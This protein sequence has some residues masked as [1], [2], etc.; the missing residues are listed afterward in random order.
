MDY[1]RREEKDYY[2]KL[3]NHVLYHV[4]EKMDHDFMY[5]QDIFSMIDQVFM[6]IGECVVT[7]RVEKAEIDS[8]NFTTVENNIHE[9]DKIRRKRERRHIDIGIQ[10][11]S[12]LVR[13]SVNRLVCEKGKEL[14]N[15][16][17]Y[18]DSI[19]QACRLSLRN[20]GFF[21]DRHVTYFIN[22]KKKYP[23]E[24]FKLYLNYFKT[25]KRRIKRDHHDAPAHHHH[26]KSAHH[27]HDAPK[28][29]HH[30]H[31]AHQHSSS[32]YD[33][34]DDYDKDSQELNIH[35]LEI[36]Y[37]FKEEYHRNHWGGIN[38]YRFD[39]CTL[40]NI[41]MRVQEGTMKRIDVE[42]EQTIECFSIESLM[43]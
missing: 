4:F 28:P 9:V 16:Y 37:V 36:N 21:N 25:K 17:A 8:F 15:S 39:V 33:Y 30:H 14:Y 18:E 20:T 43:Y 26:D 40:D 7:Q 27:H 2:V 23:C 5:N 38:D 32:K 19:L 22:D 13:L 24:F 3:S 12:E 41:K 11:L 34:E 29:A 6:Q 42:F 31:D 10:R 1:Y 35:L